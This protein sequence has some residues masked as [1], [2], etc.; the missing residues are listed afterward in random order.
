MTAIVALRPTVATHQPSRIRGTVVE[1]P[2]TRRPTTATATPAII[3][4]L[5][6][7]I[8]DVVRSLSFPTRGLTTTPRTPATPRMR[9]NAALRWSAGN[10]VLR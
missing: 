8:R 5:R 2:V 10:T 7:P 4:G 6:M 9:D 3:Q 1:V